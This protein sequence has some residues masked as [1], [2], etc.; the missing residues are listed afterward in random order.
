MSI[1]AWGKPTPDIFLAN[2][3]AA[4]SR[5]IYDVPEDRAVLAAIHRATTGQSAAPTNPYV[6]EPDCESPRCPVKVWD[7]KHGH[8]AAPARPEV[9]DV[10]NSEAYRQY[11]EREMSRSKAEQAVLDAMAAIEDEDLHWTIELHGDAPSMP[12]VGACRAELARRGL[13]P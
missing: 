6:C 2:Q 3:P 12:V 11:Q 9:N 7:R 8:P 1:D 4:P 13:K 10:V 5:S